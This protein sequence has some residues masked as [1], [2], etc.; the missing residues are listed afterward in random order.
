MTKTQ[1]SCQWWLVVLPHERIPETL[2]SHHKLIFTVCGRNST[3]ETTEN[4]WAKHKRCKHN[5]CKTS[6]SIHIKTPSRFIFLL[7]SF[8]SS[9]SKQTP[10]ARPYGRRQEVS[11]S[12]ILMQRDLRFHNECDYEFVTDTSK[13]I[14][15]RRL[16]KC[17]QNGINRLAVWN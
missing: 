14:L 2:Q 7:C 10:Q 9:F 15:T 11:T 4:T 8:F 12:S 13:P 5:M 6:P 16:F 1:F 3:L 17:P